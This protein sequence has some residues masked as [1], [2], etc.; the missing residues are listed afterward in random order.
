MP[1]PEKKP[2]EVK[3]T[4]V[5]QK[6]IKEIQ[7]KKSLYDKV[8]NSLKAKNLTDAVNYLQGWFNGV[9]P[10]AKNVILDMRAYWIQDDLAELS[11]DLLRALN[12]TIEA[13]VKEKK[14]GDFWNRYNESTFK[15]A[16]AD[17]KPDVYERDYVGHIKKKAGG[18]DQDNGNFSA[19]CDYL[20][21][22]HMMMHKLYECLQDVA[23][24]NSTYQFKG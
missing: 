4:D 23:K 15:L 6:L 1:D 7:S 8:L 13:R 10:S 9:A 16:G 20:C 12:A 18:L 5:S 11:Q 22:F 21:S 24:T 17:L 19:V 14:V 2:V 3:K